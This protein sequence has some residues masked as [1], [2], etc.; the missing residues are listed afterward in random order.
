M[1]IQKIWNFSKLSLTQKS[2]VFKKK[3]I[4]KK[5]ILQKKISVIGTKRVQNTKFWDKFLRSW[6]FY[7]CSIFKKC[8]QK[9]INCGKRRV[10][11][12]AMIS[13]GTQNVYIVCFFLLWLQFDFYS[14]GVF[15][16]QLMMNY[17][18]QNPQNGSF[19]AVLVFQ[20]LI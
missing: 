2:R 17:Y 20:Y 19:V 10:P 16:F 1:C 12:N 11:S 3:I 13:D 7:N 14:F 6:F 18:Q 8:E 5:K 4:R 15:Y 9:K